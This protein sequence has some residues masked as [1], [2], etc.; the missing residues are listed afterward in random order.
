MSV[1][2]CSYGGVRLLVITLIHGN[3]MNVSHF[4]A[5]WARHSQTYFKFATKLATSQET[6]P[7]GVPSETQGGLWMALPKC[8]ES[9]RLAGYDQEKAVSTATVGAPNEVLGCLW[10]ASPRINYIKLTYS[11]KLF[12]SESR[13][14][15]VV[16]ISKMML[17]GLSCSPHSK[18][19]C[20]VFSCKPMDVAPL[21]SWKYLDVTVSVLL[22]HRTAYECLITS[23]HI[24]YPVI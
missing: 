9:S 15:C 8:T 1:Y 10:D 11:I 3:S 23:N 22:Y 13:T 17:S 16:P 6:I 24:S 19:M 21:R 18:K 20:L 14:L 7:V 4:R 2:M 12:V 5:S